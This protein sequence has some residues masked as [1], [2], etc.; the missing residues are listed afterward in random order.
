[1]DMFEML[2]RMPAVSAILNREM[3]VVDEDGA[4][5]WTGPLTELLD[6]NKDGLDDCQVM[7]LCGLKVGE[8]AT[9]GGGAATMFT[10]RRLM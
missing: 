6:A 3:K 2:E 9:M 5:E 1:M 4:D 8:E 7:T 10:V